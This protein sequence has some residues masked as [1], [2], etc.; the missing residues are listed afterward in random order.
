MNYKAIIKRQSTII[1]VAV[2]C[3][4]LTTIG[5]S[6]ALF[7]QVE[8]NSN[9]QVVQAGSLDVA[10]GSGTASISAT[11]FEPLSDDDAL[12]TSSITGTIYIENKGTLP[13]NYTVKLGNDIESFNNR[14]DKSEN[15]KLI[16]HEHLKVAAYLDGSLVLEPVLLSELET[17]SDNEDMKI[18]FKDIINTTGTGENTATIVLKVW[19][20][21]DAPESIIGDHIYLKM[22]VTSEVDEIVAEGSSYDL[23]NKI[24]KHATDN[25]Y[26][27]TETPNFS[28]PTNDGEQGLYKTVDDL[29]ISYYFRGDV[30]NNY[31]E[32]GTYSSNGPVIGY[33]SNSINMGSQVYN[34]IEEC[35]S[36][37][38]YNVN[39]NYIYKENDPMY[40]RI[41]RINGD[42]SVRLIYDGITKTE[43]GIMHES[44]IA[45]SAFNSNYDNPKYAGYTYDDGTGVQVDSTVKGVIDTWYETY[46]EPNYGTYIADGIFCNEKPELL[47]NGYYPISERLKN[48]T[49]TLK[50]KNKNDR[51]TV[52][53]AYGNGYLTNPASLITVDEVILAGSATNINLS[54]M[55]YYLNVNDLFQTLTPAFFAYNNA[56]IYRVD[57][58]GILNEDIVSLAG[59]GVRPVINLKANIEFT[60]DGSINNPY[61]IKE[62]AE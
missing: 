42:G 33:W 21:E 13:A 45:R 59:V 4:T 5:V 20:T 36:A 32:F 26:I 25:N 38:Y 28:K 43:N 58:S 18:L 31:V 37:S 40:W 57:S 16:S 53:N 14:S 15:D 10:Y 44:N 11:E 61:Q 35:N 2:I 17:S 47:E 55:S 23:K 49:I 3:L 19:V 22:D 8:T 46:L 52:N 54:N 12:L 1:A 62:L 48:N 41:V 39:C 30:T 29:G 50:C 27:K 60:G 51:Y 7:F 56:G 24:I 9:N 6:Y 34:S